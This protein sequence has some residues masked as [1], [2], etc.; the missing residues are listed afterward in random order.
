VL[1]VNGTEL[2]HESRGSG[3]PLLLIMGATGDAGH[4]EPVA[5]LLA[6][7][8]TVVTYDRRGNGRRPRPRGWAATSPE[9]QAD[10]AAALLEALG[11]APAAVFGTSLGG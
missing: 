11:L 3:P 9:E 7:E 8:F 2:Y 4:F 10:D 6:G 1:E 5:E